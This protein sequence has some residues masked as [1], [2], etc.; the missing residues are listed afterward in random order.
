MNLQ[1]LYPDSE[2][3][4]IIGDIHTSRFHAGEVMY[5]KEAHKFTSLFMPAA[6]IFLLVTD[7]RAERL[8]EITGGDCLKEGCPQIE[9][10]M[11]LHLQWYK[12]LWDSI[13]PKSKWDTNPWVFVY[14]FKKV[15]KPEK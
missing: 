11:G 8:K 6:R 13:N 9:A 3:T 2:P 14:T 7:V 12:E 4:T 1:A 10:S 5:I 15:D